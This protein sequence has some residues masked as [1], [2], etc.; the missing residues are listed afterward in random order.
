V[1]D[2]FSFNLFLPKAAHILGISYLHVSH[3]FLFPCY[4]PSKYSCPGPAKPQMSQQAIEEGNIAS[5]WGIKM[6]ASHPSCI[7]SR[8]PKH[9]Q[10]W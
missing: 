7:S 2:S 1:L 5:E 9:I 3:R 6:K 8:D 10:Q 4:F